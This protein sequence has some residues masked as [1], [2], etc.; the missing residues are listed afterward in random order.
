MGDNG[1]LYV[2]QDLVPAYKDLVTSLATVIT[3]NQFEA[4]LLTGI[5][6][7]SKASA[8][9]ACQILHD[10][11]IATVVRG[12]PSVA[13]LA[14]KDIVCPSTSSRLHM[15]LTR[16]PFRPAV[17]IYFCI[18]SFDTIP[19]CRNCQHGCVYEMS[20]VVFRSSPASDWRILKGSCC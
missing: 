13:A 19:A 10:R 1:K 16:D 20:N 3:P 11:G 4:E 9:A 15:I 17:T 6:I 18:E 12:I 7:D 2:S 8:L 5:K 14:C